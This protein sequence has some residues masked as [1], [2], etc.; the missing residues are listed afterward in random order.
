MRYTASEKREILRLVE[1][2]DLP[3]QRTLDEL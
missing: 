1:G 3:V 2:S